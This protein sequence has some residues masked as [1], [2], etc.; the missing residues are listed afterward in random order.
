MG[1]GIDACKGTAPEHAALMENFRD[2]LLIIIM[3]RLGAK[4]GGKVQIPVSEVDGAGR[5]ALAYSVRDGV[6]HFEVR[7]KA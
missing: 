7:E 2:D 5:F 4:T 1:K 6:F 3:R